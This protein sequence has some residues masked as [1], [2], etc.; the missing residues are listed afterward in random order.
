[1]S[2]N[3]D[4]PIAVGDLVVVVKPTMCCGNRTRLG[5]IFRVNY[6]GPS[7]TK[8]LRCVYC[9]NRER[10]LVYVSPFQSVPTGDGYPLER[11]KRIPPLDELESTKTDEPMKEPA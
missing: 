9:A 1:M 3:A 2:D 6:L 4:R 10:V 7:P 11:L 5:H 8:H